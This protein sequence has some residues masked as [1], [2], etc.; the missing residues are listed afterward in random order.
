M[1]GLSREQMVGGMYTY[2]SL[3]VGLA[4]GYL[5][6]ITILSLVF[7]VLASFFSLLLSFTLHSIFSYYLR[8]PILNLPFT[9]TATLVYLSSIRY[10]NLYTVQNTRLGALNIEQ[11]PI[12]L[13]G[14]FRSTGIILFLP[15]DLIGIAVLLSMLVFSRINFF[16]CYRLLY[17]TMLLTLLKGYPIRLYRS[18][19]F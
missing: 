17:R 13:S 4:M 11:L 10:G 14:L 15:Y 9:I 5:F 19:Q 3:L 1:M 2:N 16:G 12:W 18:L 7:T 6:K 8:V